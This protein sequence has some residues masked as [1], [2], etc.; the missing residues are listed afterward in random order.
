MTH[1]KKGLLIE[2][3]ASGHPVPITHKAR[4]AGLNHYKSVP[5][6]SLVFTRERPG[7]TKR[8]QRLG[9]QPNSAPTYTIGL[10]LDEATP[11]TCAYLCGS[12]SHYS[13]PSQDVSQ[14][15]Q[16]KTTYMPCHTSAV[17][18]GIHQQK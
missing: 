17:F 18:P 3:I 12:L 2:A 11:T 15:Q 13:P 6:T 16:Q 9:A 7:V 8:M 14:K 10:A 5:T 4:M 1:W